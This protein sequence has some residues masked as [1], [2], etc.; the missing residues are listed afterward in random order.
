L[1]NN[2]AAEHASDPE[3]RQLVTQEKVLALYR[4]MADVVAINAEG[5]VIS[6][7]WNRIANRRPDPHLVTF[8][9][10]PKGKGRYPFPPDVIQK[11]NAAD[12]ALIPME[13][14]AQQVEKIINGELRATS[15]RKN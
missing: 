4:S 9:S 6:F 8:N 2:Y 15:K 1:I 5:D 7:L 11:M 13:R 10:L 3:L 12:K 14:Y